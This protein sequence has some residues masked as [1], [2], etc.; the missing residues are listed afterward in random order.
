M[1]KGYMIKAR[2][3]Q[4]NKEPVREETELIIFFPI[5]FISWRLITYNSETEL[6]RRSYEEILE[7]KSKYNKR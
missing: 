3:W 4:R 2:K 6:I 1:L 7:L 5:I